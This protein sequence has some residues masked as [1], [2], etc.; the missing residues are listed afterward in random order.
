MAENEQDPQ[1]DQKSKWQEMAED[2][3]HQDEFEKEDAELELEDDIT[4]LVDDEEEPLGS[5][6]LSGELVAA[7]KRIK[8]LEEALARMQAEAENT[9]RRAG[10][11][12]ENAHKFA[13]EKFVGE[14]VVVIDSLE[15]GLEACDKLESAEVVSVREGMELTHKQFMDTLT[16][17]GVEAIE[18]KGEKF[19]P[20][21][22][23]AVQMIPHEATANTVVDVLQPG[24]L[25]NGRL[26]RPAMVIVSKAE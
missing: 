8:E 25:L 23:N 21:H 22:H 4:G 13:L 17:F 12:V 7:S 15:R 11:Q 19:N 26:V 18:A 24:Y 9:R 20:E 10:Q 6:E 2:A 3:S 16:K 1:K 5:P 14:L